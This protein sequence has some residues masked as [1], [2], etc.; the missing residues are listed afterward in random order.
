[1]SDSSS[2]QREIEGLGA[3][4]WA[5]SARLHKAW[6]PRYSLSY[7]VAEA[8]TPY[9]PVRTVPKWLMTLFRRGGRWGRSAMGAAG[10]QLAAVS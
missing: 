3:R 2:L 9:G 4:R 5:A 1:M 10:L 8:S 7:S 6:M